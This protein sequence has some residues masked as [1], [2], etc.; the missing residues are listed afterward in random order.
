MSAAFWERLLFAGLAVSVFSA[1]FSVTL[2]ELGLGVAL[3]AVVGRN[4]SAGTSPSFSTFFSGPLRWLCAA[5]LVYLLAGVLS[6]FFGVDFWR[7]FSALASDLVK[8]AAFA[9][10]VLACDKIVVGRAKPYY[11]AG[12][13]ISAVWGIVQLAATSGPQGLGRASG[14]LSAVTYGEVMALSAVAALAAFF[15]SSGRSRVL[16]FAGALLCSAGVFAGQGRASMAAL[17]VAVL[18][19]ALAAGRGRR[20]VL[21]AVLGLLLVVGGVYAAHSQR[22]KSVPVFVAAVYKTAVLGER[23]EV[24][25]DVSGWD[26]LEMWRAGTAIWRDYPLFGV[27]PANIRKVFDFY[28]PHPLSGYG[29][30]DF[31]LG[32]VHN[33]FLQQAAERGVLGLAALLGLFCAMLYASAVW[34]RRKADE[35]TLWF[36]SALPAFLLMNLTETSFQHALPALSILFALSAAHTSSAESNIIDSPN[37]LSEGE[38]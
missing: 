27:G 11:V 22:M 28:H 10:L 18:V 20:G 12:A 5:W 30:R 32:N 23:V 26:R 19:M 15:Y 8:C 9:L 34:F 16:Y 14:S 29:G 31:G 2:C 37:S 17:L 21:L 4:L 7:S 13:C 33:L 1:T 6:S 35:N 36:L 24:S 25:K 38:S 3:T